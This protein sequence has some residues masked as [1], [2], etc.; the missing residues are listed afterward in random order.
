MFVL[1]IYSMLFVVTSIFTLTAVYIHIENPHILNEISSGGVAA[2]SSPIPTTT[3]N[4]TTTGTTSSTTSGRPTSYYHC[5]GKATVH[6]YSL[7]PPLALALSI[8]WTQERESTQTLQDFYALIA[9]SIQLSDIFHVQGNTTISNNDGSRGGGSSSASTSGG[10][11]S[12]NPS[13]VFRGLVCYYGKHYVSIFQSR[14]A[15]LHEYLLFDDHRVINIG[16]WEA[17]KQKCVK[18]C[19][20]PV[21]LLYE[22]EADR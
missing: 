15:E 1:T 19:Y 3:A 8:G 13:Y 6:Q 7:D 11:S 10:T 17:V 18:S 5:R 4:S 21:L 22:L 14:A 16:S 12:S 20:Q 2:A 9:Y